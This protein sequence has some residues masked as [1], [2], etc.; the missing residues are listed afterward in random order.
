MTE[1]TPEKKNVKVN[2]LVVQDKKSASNSG[3]EGFFAYFSNSWSEFKKVVWPKREDA[4]RMTVFVIVF[5]AVLSIFIYAADTAI[6]WLFFDVL[7]RREG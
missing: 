5:V 4:V 7:L 2:Q 6:S 3:K 1:H